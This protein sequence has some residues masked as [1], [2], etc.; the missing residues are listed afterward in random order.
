MSLRIFKTP[1]A[2]SISSQQIAQAKRFAQQ[3][4]P[5][6]NYR[7]S[8]QTNRAKIQNDH[9]VSKLGEEAVAQ[10]F[11]EHDWQIK[12]PD[13]SIYE[14]KNKSWEEDLY[15]DDIGL[16]VKTQK[17]SSATR[18]GLSWTFQ[19]SPKRRDPILDAPLAW[20]CFVLCDEQNN[21]N[22]LVYPPYQIHELVF[23]D[24]KL[25]RLKGKKKVLYAE[26]LPTLSN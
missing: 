22:C 25:A 19:S 11:R 16:A 24:P 17:Q 4:I 3:V 6:V 20:V 9:F 21:Y 26:D 8:N 15:V 7:D 23:K 2:V 5:T 12:G 13:Y 14:G 18:Y 1:I 10:V